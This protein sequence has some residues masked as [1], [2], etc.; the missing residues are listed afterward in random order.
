[1]LTARS[2]TSDK[3]TGLK[4]GADDYMVKP[5]DYEELIVRLHTLIRRN[6]SVKSEYINLRDL[7]IHCD[8]KTVKQNGEKK[9][10]SAKEFDLL[11]YLTKNAGKIISKEEL[12]EKVWGEYD[13]LTLTLKKL[14]KETFCL[15]C[16][17][18]T[19]ITL[20][21]SGYI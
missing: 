15:F 10:L 9:D 21:H 6:Q 14:Q 12:L 8:T 1:M 13:A 20:D 17:L 16:S 7:E 4:S 18:C 2:E 11:C 19:I 5:F 3:I